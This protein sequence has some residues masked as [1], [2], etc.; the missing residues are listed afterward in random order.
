MYCALCPANRGAT[1]YPCPDVPWHQVQLRTLALSPSP[2][3]EG[4]VEA[5]IARIAILNPMRFMTPSFHALCIHRNNDVYIGGSS[6]QITDVGRDRFNLRPR[7]IVCR[8]CH[9]GGCINRRALA[10]LR[11]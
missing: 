10:S 11:L 1:V 9:D 5:T 6:L 8:R 7:Q 2:A 3:H 4:T